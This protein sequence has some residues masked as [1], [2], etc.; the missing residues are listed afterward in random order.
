M[1]LNEYN[2]ILENL[3]LSQESADTFSGASAEP[4]SAG[5]DVVIITD[6]DCELL[7]NGTRLVILS[8]GVGTTFRLPLGE[9]LVTV[10]TTDGRASIEEILT[11]QGGGQKVVNLKVKEKHQAALRTEAE[12]SR[13]RELE[14]QKKRDEAAKQEKERQEKIRIEEE[15]GR[16]RLLDE[17][18]SQ[19]TINVRLQKRKQA[20][21]ISF[22]ITFFIFIFV[23]D[24]SSSGGFGLFCGVLAGGAFFAYRYK[25]T[26]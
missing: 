4:T 26:Q 1:A 20:A 15:R 8:A 22:M 11:I 2:K 18:Q 13:K 21:A 12:S 3:G 17:Q 23:A 24:K 16:K 14:E 19:K 6:M 10:R 7:V 5:S 9:S 25:S